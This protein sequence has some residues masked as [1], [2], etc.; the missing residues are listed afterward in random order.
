MQTAG[1]SCV[2][3]CLYF[4][5]AA[6]M[7]S[8]SFTGGRCIYRKR[9]SYCR[10]FYLSFLLVPCRGPSWRGSL[11]VVHSANLGAVAVVNS[12]YSKVPKLIHL[13]RWLFFI[14]AHFNFSV[15]VV[16]VPRV[17]NGWADAISRA[18]C[19]IFLQRSRG[20]SAGVSPLHPACWSLEQLPD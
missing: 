8:T 12:G 20:L 7:A 17:Q 1:T 13:L 11:V 16:Y 19:L 5:V 3:G 10:S 14:R 4:L 6:A 2:D 18:D 9:A 15:R